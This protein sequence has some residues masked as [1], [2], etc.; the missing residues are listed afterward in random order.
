MKNLILGYPRGWNRWQCLEKSLK[1][2][3][4]EVDVATEDFDK[5]VGPY[6]RIYTVS[7]SLL[8]I[9]AKLEK[10]WGLKN[11]SEKAADILSDKSK[12]DSWCG[13]IGLQDLIPYSIR[14]T[15]P[16]HLDRFKESPFIIKPI[17]G[18]GGKP[19]GLNY[20]SFKNKRDFLLS[21]DTSF[22]TENEKGW[23][24]SEFNNR[25]NHYIA[26]EQLPTE[27]EMWAAYYYVNETGVLKDLLWVKGKVGYNQIDEYKYETKCIEW[28][29]VN[30]ED[31]PKD[32]IYEC[33]RFMERLVATLN[34]RN[35]FFSGPDFYKF[36][37]VIKTI[38]C[39]PRI[40]QGLQ[41]MDSVH[42]YTI[43]P[44]ILKGKPFSYNKQMLWKIADLKPGKIKSVKD[45]SHLKE[46]WCKTNNDRLKPGET[47]QKFTHITSE[48][49]PRIAFLITGINESDIRK[50]Y[51]TV[52]NQLQECIN[53]Y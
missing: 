21:I 35:M 51:Q 46:Y 18:S 38:D 49:V 48:R 8:P 31:V 41:Q 47:I 1:S 53:Y 33:Q 12:F 27:S 13:T 6:D 17:I 5:I 52:N 9:Q 29:S 43:V 14:P 20:I 19:G 25:I 26:Q 28:M 4:Q 42:D 40:G 23:E 34:L 39:N 24:D 36:N 45:L 2:I 50:K 32:I 37:N 11:V 30:K 16:G 10:Q 15:N 3:G 22:F 44:K 7:E